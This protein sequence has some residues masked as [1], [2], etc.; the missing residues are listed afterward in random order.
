MI[1]PDKA[2]LYITAIEDRHYKDDK[3]NCK[4]NFTEIDLKTE[5]FFLG[6]DNVYGF[7]M[8]CIKKLA[9]T[10]PLVDVVEARQICTN[11]SIIKD[12]DLY[13]VKLEDLTFESEFTLVA[14]RDDYIHAF[15]AYFS[16]EF[17]KSHRAI[18]FSTCKL[19]I[20]T[21]LVNLS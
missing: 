3:I 15:V 13:T 6:W 4:F 9:I 10:E 8:S 7:D 17:S 5:Y 18:G 19:I 21:L 11:Y 2:T 14:K 1:F 16:V 12:I 20:V